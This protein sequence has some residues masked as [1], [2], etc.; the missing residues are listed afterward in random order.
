MNSVIAATSY[1]L[2]HT[3]DMILHNGTTITTEKIVNPESEYLKELPNHIR[4]YEQALAY[5][6]NQTYIGN[7]TPD[8]LA[9]IP[10]PWYEAGKEVEAKREGRFGEILPQDEFY[11]LMQIC[12]V[13]DLLVLEKG[14]A[15]AT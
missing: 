2:V 15:A 10:Q 14:F 11:V 12:D 13:F 7:M 6:P 8:E 1:V 4:T 9:A 3:P 5:A